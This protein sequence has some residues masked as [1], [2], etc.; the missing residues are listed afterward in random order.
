MAVLS[1][2]VL[3]VA[4]DQKPKVFPIINNVGNQGPRSRGA[5]TPMGTQARRGLGSP[6][7]LTHDF[8]NMRAGSS[9]PRM[10]TDVTNRAPIGA[11][12]DHSL[13]NSS[14]TGPAN[15]QKCN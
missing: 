6:T 11:H 9:V 4:Q 15:P 12:S 1:N 13:H 2:M 10:H 5:S 14:R 7:N 8:G 3:N